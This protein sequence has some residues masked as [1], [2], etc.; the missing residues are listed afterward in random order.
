MNVNKS[1]HCSLF[2]QSIKRH[3]AT[4]YNDNG[5]TADVILSLNECLKTRY[6]SYTNQY[7]KH[8]LSNLPN[9]I[10]FLQLTVKC[11]P[12]TLPTA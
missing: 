12:S 5:M 10:D 11:M 4:Y 8:F 1:V 7:V 3:L 6:T 9:H 2:M